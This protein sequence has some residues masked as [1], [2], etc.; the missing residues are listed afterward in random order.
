LNE[1]ATLFFS[2]PIKIIV[3]ATFI[4]VIAKGRFDKRND[5]FLLA[6]MLVCLS[7]EVLNCIFKIHKLST[8]ALITIVT[9]LHHGLWLAMLSRGTAYSKAIYFAIAA[10]VTMAVLNLTSFEGTE[11]FNYYTFVFGS[12]L[13]IGFFIIESYRRLRNEDLPFFLSIEYVLF[14]SPVLLF[15]GLSFMFGF[16]SKILTSAQ[17]LDYKLYDIIVPAVS[18]IYYSAVNIYLFSKK[19]TAWNT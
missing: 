15:F 16:K 2:K 10:F 11:H 14:F 9:I 18:V 6:I 4:A 8:A 3:L 7:N 1:F 13:Y 5:L 17:I 19:D 12:F